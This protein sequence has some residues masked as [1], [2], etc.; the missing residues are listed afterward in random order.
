MS[1]CDEWVLKTID[2]IYEAAE[3]PEMWGPAMAGIARGLGCAA[4]VVT[5]EDLG[6]WRSN[7]CLSNSDPAFLV[8]YN[9][10][11]H[12]VNPHMERARHLLAPGRVVAS[13]EV[14]PDTVTFGSEY[15]TDFLRPQD[16]FYVF[17]GAVAREQSLISVVNFVRPYRAGPPGADD[18]ENL[19]KVMPHLH[20]AMK[21]RQALHGYRAALESLNSLS[22]GAV[23]VNGAGRVL[24]LNR[25]AEQMAAQND[26]ISIKQ[27]VLVTNQKRLASMLRQACETA[28]GEGIHPG[29]PLTIPRSS[30]KR[31]YVVL[32]TPLK[33]SRPDFGEQ[34]PSSMVFITDPESRPEEIDQM[35]RRL[36]HLTPA[37]AALCGLLAQDHDL[38]RI[39]EKQGIT[40]STARTHLRN[41]FQK[42][43]INRQ[44][45]LTS[46]LAMAF[47]PL[48]EKRS[49]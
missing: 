17:G 39:C 13:N 7:S 4:F 25:A 49:S 8:K 5:I 42:L 47:G 26:G 32:V 20:R 12:S 3:E 45:E 24:F 1:A 28:I 38:N 43:G 9:E 44:A 21:L 29:G 31:P 34:R 36:F 18:I 48:S 22:T 30:N 46:F 40:R 23:L 15:Y 11:Y 35:L 16:W 27:G 41:S 14:C 37:E 33:W 19:S 10:Y 6:A 2:A